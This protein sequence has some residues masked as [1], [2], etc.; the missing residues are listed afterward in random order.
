MVPAVSGQKYSAAD[1]LTEAEECLSEAI[2]NLLKNDSLRLHYKEK[3]VERAKDFNPNI[4]TK[5]WLAL[6]K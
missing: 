2:L 6:M 4:I 1:P 5:Q 3:I